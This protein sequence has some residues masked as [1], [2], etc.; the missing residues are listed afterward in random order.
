MRATR[1]FILLVGISVY[2]R[3]RRAG[4]LSMYSDSDE[5]GSESEDGGNGLLAELLGTATGG[6]HPDGD[7]NDSVDSD[8]ELKATIRR[9]KRDFE[10][11]ELAIMQ[12]L[13]Q[14]QVAKDKIDAQQK[15]HSISA[16]DADVKNGQHRE[17]GTGKNEVASSSSESDGDERGSK[18]R[19]DGEQRDDSSH[20]RSSSSKQGSDVCKNRTSTESK[21]CLCYFAGL[22]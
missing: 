8:E 22:F 3:Y 2:E 13:Q 14:Q 11:T 21:F 10:A 19:S 5:T 16:H 9:K 6:G 7:H 20:K 17:P 18:K 4:G 1:H 15:K 12:R